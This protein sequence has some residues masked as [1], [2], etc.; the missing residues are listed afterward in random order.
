MRFLLVVL[1]LPLTALADTLIC[2]GDSQTAV[3]PPVQLA[4]TFCAKMAGARTPVNKGVG[5][6][7]TVDALARL[8]GD[9]LTQSGSCVTVMFGAGDSEIS[10]SG[11]YSYTGW[12]TGPQTS[13]VSVASFTANLT[14]IVQQILKAGK[15]VTLLTPWTNFNTANLNQG[16]FYSDAVKGVGAALGV[17]VL[18]AGDIL[19]QLWTNSYE[20][21][22]RNGVVHPNAPTL[23]SLMAD[24]LHPSV[25][26]HTHIANLCSKPQNVAACAC[27]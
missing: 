3:R 27:N 4:D 26:G 11:S 13:E 22:N 24:D 20:W 5:G 17:P 10:Y 18:D 16:R 21:L 1:L 12:W 7:S 8:N 9:V 6:D 25:V 15:Q 14:S 2:F 19:R 23:G